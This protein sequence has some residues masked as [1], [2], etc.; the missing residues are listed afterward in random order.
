[1][2]LQGELAT[3]LSENAEALDA[4]EVDPEILV[5]K[6]AAH[7]SFR[8][9][10]PREHGGSGGT[11]GEAVALLV[12]IAQRSLT[13]AFVLWAQRT[14]VEY[15]LCTPNH[16]LREQWLPAL[17]DGRTAGATGLSNA[18][19]FLS[20]IEELAV[21][22]RRGERALLLEGSAP[23]V[24]NLRRSGFIVAITALAPDGEGSW[25]LAVPSSAPGLARSPDLSLLALN[26][27][28]TA[29]LRFE[30]TEVNE[31]FV[32]HRD[33]RAFIAEV[34]P[35]FLGLQCGLAIGLAQKSLT[36]ARA[37]SA[38]R[39]ATLRGRLEDTTARLSTQVSALYAGLEGG[40][41]R[42]APAELFALKIALAELAQAAV[43][44]ELAT[45]GGSAYLTD[46]DGGFARRWREAAFIPIVTP[47]VTQLEH[48]L[49][50]RRAE[51]AA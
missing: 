7:G 6:L 44:L 11:I 41:F 13:A 51:E 8:V 24:T 34:R 5:Q 1:M 38:K 3:F 17:L 23:W 37:A 33:A 29:A 18:I 15:L 47:S 12:S 43:G 50:R 31:A 26:G 30:S 32:L 21:T 14:F 19:K 35:A 4:N 10:V 49:A 36:I 40:R 16:A 48:E 9:G 22:T 20:G 45:S 28:N 46:R 27:S 39:A 2:T 42:E 25:V